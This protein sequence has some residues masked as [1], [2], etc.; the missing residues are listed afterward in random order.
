MSNFKLVLRK[1]LML[2]AILGP[3]ISYCGE[4]TGTVKSTLVGPAGPN[5]AFVTLTG[6]NSSLP[7]CST[8]GNRYVIDISTAGG[9]MAYSK[10]LLAEAMN[11]TI[12]IYG[13][14]TCALYPNSEDVNW[15]ANP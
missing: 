4:T 8:V 12:H 6:V 1:I 7:A 14:G 13:S 5:Y 11:S 9:K 2:A 15:I 10:V 3:S